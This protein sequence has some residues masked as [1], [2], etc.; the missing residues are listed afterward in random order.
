LNNGTQAVGSQSHI[1]LIDVRVPHGNKQCTAAHN[2]PAVDTAYG[3][4]VYHRKMDKWI[5]K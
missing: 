1:T 2:I 3:E 5:D 4:H